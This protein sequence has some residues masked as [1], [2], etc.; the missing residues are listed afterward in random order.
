MFAEVTIDVLELSVDGWFGAGYGVK[1]TTK[2]DLLTADDVTPTGGGGSWVAVYLPCG[3]G[4]SAE[5]VTGTVKATGAGVIVGDSDS[6][7]DG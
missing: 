7:V 3:V 5:E 6:N 2:S 1:S 4:M